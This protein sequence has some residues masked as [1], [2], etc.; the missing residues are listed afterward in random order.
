MKNVFF[1]RFPTGTDLLGGK[2]SCKK[3]INRA[4]AIL[5]NEAF[6]AWE[7]LNVFE[8]VKSFVSK[9]AQ[10]KFLSKNDQESNAFSVLQ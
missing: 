7:D 8:E 9:I 6:K 4:N 5:L 1:L 3:S 2:V 10:N